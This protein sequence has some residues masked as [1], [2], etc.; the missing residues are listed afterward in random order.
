MNVQ[1]ANGSRKALVADAGPLCMVMGLGPQDLDDPGKLLPES[2]EQQAESIF[3]N[4]ERVLADA[5]LRRADIV[6]I[7]VHLTN[8]ERVQ[9]RF[10]RKF[11][12]WA[13]SSPLPPH[14][15]VGVA[16]LT[17][18]AQVEMDFYVKRSA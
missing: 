13:G 4:L 15:I 8:F 6:G 10:Q 18:Q 11:A 1:T 2:V 14:S 9:E 12:Q 7:R 16:A 17:R 3:R 5:G